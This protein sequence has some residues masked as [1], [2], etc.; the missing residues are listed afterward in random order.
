MVPML[1]W[2]K[3]TL[4]L[5]IDPMTNHYFISSY[6]FSWL[7][8]IVR[9]YESLWQSQVLDECNKRKHQLVSHMRDFT[10]ADLTIRITIPG[11]FGF[12]IRFN[13]PCCA[14]A[15]Y[16]G[17]IYYSFIRLRSEPDCDLVG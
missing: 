13:H 17:N 1:F 8:E 11:C 9:F 14:A 4:E 2:T 3:T 10:H 15:Y 16:S 7:R 5:E 6:Q 12:T